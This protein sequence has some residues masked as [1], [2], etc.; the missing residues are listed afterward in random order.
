MET[1]VGHV[2]YTHAAEKLV[3]LQIKDPAIAKLSGQSFKDAIAKEKLAARPPKEKKHLS[4]FDK[5][6]SVLVSAGI[7]KDGAIAAIKEQF[8]AQGK[9]YE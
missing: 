5:A 8:K 9:T 1:F 2:S 6:V 4:D 7:N 3:K